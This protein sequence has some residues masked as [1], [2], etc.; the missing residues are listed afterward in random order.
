MQ[1]RLGI[2]VL[3]IS[4]NKVLTRLY[5]SH[6]SIRSA[7]WRCWFQSWSIS[8]L[9]SEPVL[10][11]LSCSASFCLFVFFLHGS[12]L[13][14]DWELVA[15]VYLWF[16]KGFLI[17]SLH[18]CKNCRFLNRQWPGSFLYRV[19][20]L[21]ASSCGYLSWKQY[22]YLRDCPLLHIFLCWSSVPKPDLNLISSKQGKNEMF[23]YKVLQSFFLTRCWFWQKDFLFHLLRISTF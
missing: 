10:W 21:Y 1:L 4:G 20:G 13:S 16:T 7:S 3:G 12:R 23:S 9:W 22:L 19:W 8:F 6:S 11:H 14:Y 18:Y 5:S 2:A 15:T 17:D